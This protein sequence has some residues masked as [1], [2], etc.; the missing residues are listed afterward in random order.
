MVYSFKS[1]SVG[2]GNTV[3]LCKNPEVIRLT[4][5]SRFLSSA[6]LGLLGDTMPKAKP[7]QVI[8][9]RIEFN[10]KERE[11]L[12]SLVVGQTIKNVALP[13]AAVAI[14]GSA[15]YLSYKALKSAFDW[16]NDIIDDIKQT[17]DIFQAREDIVGGVGVPVPIKAWLKIKKWT[18]G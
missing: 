8:V 12:E 3:G 15:S 14:V 4:A 6:P 2:A 11:M 7:D 9:H 16:G 18:F 10:N 13:T 5:R 1:S 17:E